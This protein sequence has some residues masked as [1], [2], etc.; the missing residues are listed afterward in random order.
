MRSGCGD[1][2]AAYIRTQYNT[3]GRTIREANI[4]A[5]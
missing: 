3:I 2:F 1:E 4:K 5:E